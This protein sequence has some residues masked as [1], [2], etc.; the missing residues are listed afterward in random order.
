MGYLPARQDAAR[1]GSGFVV[2]MG[3]LLVLKLAKIVLEPVEPLFPVRAILLH[4]IG[5]LPQGLGFE[6]A[7]PPLGRSAAG[8]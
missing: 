5:D 1:G 6:L 2:V 7:G 4:P 3:F 8:D